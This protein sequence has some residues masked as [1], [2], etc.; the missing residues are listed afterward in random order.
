MNFLKNTV[1]L[2]TIL[3]IGASLIPTQLAYAQ[4]TAFNYQ[5]YLRD[6]GVPANGLYDFQFKLYDAAVAGSQV[7]FTVTIDDLSV[8][9]GLFTVL[10]SSIGRKDV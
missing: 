1:L 10:K 6:G 2:W 9:N 5:G 8:A 3:L 4:S 7:G